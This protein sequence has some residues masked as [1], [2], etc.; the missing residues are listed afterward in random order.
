MS[1]ITLKQRVVTGFLFVLLVYSTAVALQQGP[2]AWWSFDEQTARVSLD[3][4][5]KLADE[6]H[7]NYSYVKGVSGNCL[8]FDGYTTR[9]VRSAARVPD[10]GDGL[11]I[12]AWVA[13]QVYPWNWTAIVSHEQQHTSGYF[14]GIDADGYVGLGV[15][16]LSGG[17]WHMCTSAERVELLKWS[18]IAGVYDGSGNLAVYINGQL[19][20][21]L[22]VPNHGWEWMSGVKQAEQTDLWIGSSHTKMYPKYTERAPSRKLLSQMVF[23]GLI[24]EVKIYDRG[25]TGEQ[26]REAFES[27]RPSEE[28]PLAWRRLPRVPK[29]TANFGAYYTRL[30]YD[31]AW[32]KLWRVGPYADVLV[33]FDTAPVAIT[34][35]RGMNYAASYVTENDIWMGDQSLES[36]HEWGCSEHMSDKQCRYAHVRIIEN[37]D[38]RVVV[39]W[40]YN[41]CDIRYQQVNVDQQ[42]GLGDWVDEYFIIYPDCVAVRKQVL[43]SSNFGVALDTANWRDNVPWHQFQETIF[44]NQPGT[45]PEDNVELGAMTLANMDGQSHTYYWKKNVQENDVEIDS[46][47]IQITNLKSRYRPFIIFEPGVKIDLWIGKRFSCWN[48]WPVAQLPNDGRVASAPDRP[49]HTSLS[50][51]AP[52]V[53]EAEDNSHIAV[54]LYGLTDKPIGQLLPL[55]KSWITP[56]KLKV[57]SGGFESEGY[58]RYQRAYVLKRLQPGDAGLTFEILGSADS[59]VVNPAFIVKNWGDRPTTLK[60]DG[61]RIR[62]GRTF[63]YGLRKNLDGTTDLIGWVKTTSKNALRISFSPAGD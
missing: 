55:A 12:E 34:F 51:G 46:P 15:C 16:L 57:M 45:R 41:P 36:F 11:T 39:H 10:V 7:G 4:A 13:P 33:T 49:S 37:N 59:P 24:D 56:P 17:Q 53:H 43:W 29:D 30:M 63:R 21:S 52:V 35:W 31:T 25:L 19:S 60:L 48:H 47:N 26:V 38:A 9:I 20:G 23:D 54:S 61:N 62:R 6:I 50:C 58:D 40:R 18:H 22:S 32:E 44:F 3:S 28:Q 5:A 1:S 2:V 14:F 42:T 27:V 8:K